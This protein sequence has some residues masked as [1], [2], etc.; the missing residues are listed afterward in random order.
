MEGEMVFDDDDD[1]SEDDDRTVLSDSD[2]SNDWLGAE[3]DNDDE[4]DAL[5]H[6]HGS[7]TCRNILRRARYDHVRDNDC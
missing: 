4:D 3:D 2:W 7:R 6:L 1:E 5:E